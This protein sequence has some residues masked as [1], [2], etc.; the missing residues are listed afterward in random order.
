MLFSEDLNT[1]AN[2][3]LRDIKR[4]KESPKGAIF[5]PIK[6]WET[7]NISYFGYPQS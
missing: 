6:W 4:A 2:V 1:F 7:K 5:I 3:K